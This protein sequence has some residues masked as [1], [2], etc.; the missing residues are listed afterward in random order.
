MD[1]VTKTNGELGTIGGKIRDLGDQYTA[2]GDQ[3]FAPKDGPQFIGPE[4]EDGKDG[5]AAR[6]SSSPQTCHALRAMLQTPPR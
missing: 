2:L 6:K 5:K 4:D 3:K 1:I